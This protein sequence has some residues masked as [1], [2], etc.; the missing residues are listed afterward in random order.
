MT[1]KAKIN[2]FKEAIEDGIMTSKRFWH[3]VKPFLTSSD[4]ISSNFIFIE[5]DDNLLSNEQEL[6]ALFNE[7]YE[8]IVEKTSGKKVLS[9]GNSSDTC[10]DEMTVKDIISIYTNQ[11]YKIKNLCVPE[12]RFDLP[13]A[14][15]IDIK[16]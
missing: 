12:N 5:N 14:S 13:Y 2:F 1:K 11:K 16:K 6:V 10:Q 3:T 9:R 8:N 15:T 4:C 7:H